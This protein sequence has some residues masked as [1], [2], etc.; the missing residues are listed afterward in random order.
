MTRANAVNEINES[1][2]VADIKNTGK[3]GL[4]IPAL[5]HLLNADRKRELRKKLFVA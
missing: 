1:F 4:R 2:W 5:F 3:G